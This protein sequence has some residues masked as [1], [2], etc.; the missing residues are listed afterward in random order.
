[1]TEDLLTLELLERLALAR[2]YK[3]G[4]VVVGLECDHPAKFRLPPPW[5][6][7]D[8]AEWE[9]A[10]CGTQQAGRRRLTNVASLLS[11][12]PPLSPRQV[13]YLRAAAEDPEPK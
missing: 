3:V 2:A 1:M 8:P 10:V 9:C 12:A 4:L 7:D 13:D 5:P 6:T 11:P